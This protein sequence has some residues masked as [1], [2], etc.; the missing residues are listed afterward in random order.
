MVHLPS[1]MKRD[2]SCYCGLLLLEFPMVPISSV[3]EP[4]LPLSDCEALLA[5]PPYL[6]LWQHESI[7]FIVARLWEKMLSP[8]VQALTDNSGGCSADSRLG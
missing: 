5:V 6:K 2:R 1:H 4:E 3:T 8:R 7:T